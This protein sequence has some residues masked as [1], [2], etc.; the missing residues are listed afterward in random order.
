VSY[1]PEVWL[2]DQ[3]ELVPTV[4]ASY[5]SGHRSDGTGGAKPAPTQRSPEGFLAETAPGWTT[6]KRCRSNRCSPEAPRSYSRGHTQTRRSVC[7]FDAPEGAPHRISPA[8]TCLTPSREETDAH[9]ATLPRPEPG[10]SFPRKGTQASGEARCS[11]HC[12]SSKP[13]VGGWPASGPGASVAEPAEAGD[14]PRE[15]GRT[16]GRYSASWVLSR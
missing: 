9:L 2:A 5:V 12:R 10:E 14:I 11:P 1:D 7:V 4:A 8:A 13:A 16:E 15:A 3:P 6:W